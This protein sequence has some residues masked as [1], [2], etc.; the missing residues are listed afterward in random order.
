MLYSLRRRLALLISPEL[1]SYDGGSAST[2]FDADIA[3]GHARARRSFTEV[4]VQDEQGG[5]WRRGWLAT[6]GLHFA[7]P[8]VAGRL[9]EACSAAECDASC[10]TNPT[11]P[12]AIHSAPDLALPRSP[13][14]ETQRA[15]PARLD[16][17]QSASEARPCFRLALWAPQGG[18]I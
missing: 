13:D 3:R 4:S 10:Q 17:D 1:G 18:S 15:S 11:A 8:R 9:V 6:G 2:F 12:D 5:P 7:I 14:E 16:G